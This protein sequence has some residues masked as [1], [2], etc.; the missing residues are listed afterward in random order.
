M[1]RMNSARPRGVQQST[2]RIARSNRW[3]E[4]GLASERV[5]AVES[6]MSPSWLGLITQVM[7][8]NGVVLLGPCSRN[9]A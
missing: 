6:D 2:W 9:R 1:G 3:R 8:M 4:T 5:P 7:K